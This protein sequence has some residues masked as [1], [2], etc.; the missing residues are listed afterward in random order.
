MKT[1]VPSLIVVL[2]AAPIFCMGSQVALAADPKVI[3]TKP[4]K[5][6]NG[7][8]RAYVALGAKGSPLAL[9]VSLDKDALAGLPKEPNLTS[10]CFD[11][12]GNGKMDEHECLGDYAFIFALPE[13]EAARAVAPFRWVSLNWN[14]HGHIAPAPPPW[15]APHFD[16]HFYIQEREAVKLIRTGTCGELIDCEDFKKATK[17]VPAKYIHRD[18]INVG[19]AVPEMGNH[20]INSKAPELA[21][22][23][24]PFTHTFIYGAYDGRITFLEPMITH[25]YLASNP[26][27]CARIKQPEVWEIAGSYPTKYCIRYLDRMGR[28]TVSLE[29]FVRHSAK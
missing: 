6:G 12:N 11:K 28:Y 20:L 9:G 2:V 1:L 5:V 19:A 23:G 25:A 4:Q 16:F 15:A 24:P 26:S 27:M 22:N 29:E 3:A 7:W 17:A 18:H 14:P 21:K 13:G 10:R 8:A